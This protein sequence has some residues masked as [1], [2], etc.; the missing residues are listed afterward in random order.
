M[1]SRCTV[2]FF[3]CCLVTIALMGC[4]APAGTYGYSGPEGTESPTGETSPST[5]TSE[6]AGGASCLEIYNAVSVCYTSYYECTAACADQACADACQVSYTGCYDAEFALG[7]SD[8]QTEFAALRTCEEE[9]YQGCYDQGLEVYDPCAE[10]C[11]DDAC[12]QQCGA[13]AN[14]VLQGC[15]VQACYGEYSTCGVSTQPEDAGNDSSGSTGSGADSGG[16]N[17]NSGSSQTNLSCSELYECEDAC[18][19]NQSCG[20]DCYDRA[21]GQARGEWTSLIQCGQQMCDGLVVDAAEYRECL[22]HSCVAEYNV[23]F[24]NGPGTGTN[25]GGSGGG[26]TCGEGYS[27]VQSCYETAAD[28]TSF[29][30]CVDGCY[31]VMSSQGTALMNSL[32]SCSNVQCVNVPGPIENYYRCQEDFCPD[33]YNACIGDTAS[34]GSCSNSGGNQGAPSAHATCLEIHEGIIA[35]CVPV[36]SECVAA[37]SNDDCAQACAQTME[38]CIDGQQAGAPD[39]AVASFQAMYNCRVDNYQSCY[40]EANAYYMECTGACDAGDTACQN[41]CNT[42]AG[43]TYEQC[44]ETTCAAEYAACGM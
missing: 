23:C 15:M 39:T 17:P 5:G 36:H 19:G 21:T 25:P 1:P 30:S 33:E 18:N 32:V 43:T 11:S 38:G 27:C 16:S 22:A 13:Q 20:Q 31:D 6:A 8:A 26:S 29:Y 9:V 2:I 41:A 28:E 3:W 44:Y 7:S 34:A 24:T 40:D 10:A 37:C 42:N 12:L 35:L 14:D 4:G